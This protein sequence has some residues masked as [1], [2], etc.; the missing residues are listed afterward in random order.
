M[1]LPGSRHHVLQD[2]RHAAG[3]D[4]ELL[5]RGIPVFQR[6]ANLQ[7]PLAFGEGVG[8][9]PREAEGERRWPRWNRIVSEG[10]VSKFG[11]LMAQRLQVRIRSRTVEVCG[12]NEK[13][14]HSGAVLNGLMVT[15]DTAVG[16]L[17]VRVFADVV[18]QEHGHRSVSI[19]RPERLEL[20]VQK[21]RIY[22]V[23]VRS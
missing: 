11:N 6:I 17:A 21:A 7:V 12:I 19:I 22:L 14:E 16:G 15:F 3:G 13:F 5:L 8:R 10:I 18:E 1:H 2:V 4:N 9:L 23:R 20:G